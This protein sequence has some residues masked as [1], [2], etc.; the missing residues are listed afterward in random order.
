LIQIQPKSKD[1]SNIFCTSTITGVN[2]LGRNILG[3]A[4]SPLA[5]RHGEINAT[6]LKRKLKET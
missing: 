4:I 5:D 6:F 2:A 1:M 3:A